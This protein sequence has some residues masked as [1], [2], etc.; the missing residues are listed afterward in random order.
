MDKKFL[1]SFSQ[2]DQ[3]F[4]TQ[5]ISY[6]YIINRGDWNIPLYIYV[7]IYIIVWCKRNVTRYELDH[8]ASKYIIE[9]V[10]V[11]VK[12]MCCSV[13]LRNGKYT[14]TKSVKEVIFKFTSHWRFYYKGANHKILSDCERLLGR[15]HTIL[16]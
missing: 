6:I 16:T 1:V 9:K 7:Y 13:V 3:Y 4:G 8:V 10:I 5:R 11:D 2:P 14:I 12:Q 15:G